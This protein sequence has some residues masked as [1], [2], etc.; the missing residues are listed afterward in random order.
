MI[1]IYKFQGF[2]SLW[3]LT[4]PPTIFQLYRDGQFYWWRKPDYPEKTTD[5]SQVTAKLYH[6]MLYRVHLDMNGFKLTTLVVIS[7]DDINSLKSNYHKFKE[8]WFHIILFMSIEW[9]IWFESSTKY[10]LV[11]KI[12]QFK[13]KWMVCIQ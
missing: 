13:F 1:Y 11:D 9:K 2:P 10:V 4:P 8:R 3:C 6:I 5:L 7:T 12:L